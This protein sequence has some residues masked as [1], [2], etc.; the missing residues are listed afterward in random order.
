MQK[1]KL[2]QQ[3]SETAALVSDWKNSIAKIETQFNTANAALMRAK[4]HRETH[5]LKA[6][7]GDAAAIEAIKAARDAQRDAEDLLADLKAALPEAEAQLAEAQKAAESARRSLAELHAEKLK[8]QRIDIASQMGGV[9]ADYARLYAEYEKL[10][11]E[12]V[13]MDMLPRSLHGMNDHEGAVGL[14]RVRA[15]L[16]PFFWKLFPGAIHDEMKAE[17]LATSEARFW[18]LAPEHDEKSK[19]A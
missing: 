13:N 6:S 4:K 9:I 5:A 16:P 12:I 2:E 7:M 18:N 11:A 1:Q 14:R 3:V 19:A 17:N 8:R 15:S 10:G